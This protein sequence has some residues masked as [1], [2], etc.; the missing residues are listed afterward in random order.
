MFGR[1]ANA[2]LINVFALQRLFGF[3]LQAVVKKKCLL[4]VYCFPHVF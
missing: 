4:I 3:Q 1:F 2:V